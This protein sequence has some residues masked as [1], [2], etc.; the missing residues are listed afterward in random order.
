MGAPIW[1]VGLL[2]SIPFYGHLLSLFWAS[3][4]VHFTSPLAYVSFA[5]AVTRVLFLGMAWVQGPTAFVTCACLAQFLGSVHGPAYTEVIRRIYPEEIRGKAM[6]S[7]RMAS[8]VAMMLSAWI[9]G[10]LLDVAG[11]KLVLPAAALCG[12]AASWIFSQTPYPALADSGRPGGTGR[13][14]GI[15]SLPA[16][17]RQ[18][19]DLRRFET[20]FLL[21]GF[22]NLMITPL[23]P[24]L[25]VDRLGVSNFF[26][27]KLA[28][29]TALTRL[30][31]LYFWGNRI[32]RRGAHQAAVEATL[33]IALVPIC[34]ALAVSPGPLVLAA[35]ISGCAFAGLELAVF[36]SMIEMSPP[37]RDPSTT[38]AVHQTMLGIRGVTAPMVGTLLL[39]RG[40]ELRWIFILSACLA[41]AGA[42]LVR[43]SRK[44]AF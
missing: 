44:T 21:F 42:F 39:A 38:M 12:V 29:V 9:G 35:A 2:A 15:L 34:Y 27:G 36:S 37:G 18:M 26:V 19:P 32:D 14:K 16:L 31:T 25:L 23:I 1:Q 28:F 33:L 17:L 11:F 6:G 40:L 24:V 10:K 7:V 41:A 30:F 3:R 20:G 5:T 43:R 13:M 4:Q 22:G 8:S